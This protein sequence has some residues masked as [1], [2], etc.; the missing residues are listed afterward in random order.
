VRRRQNAGVA[1]IEQLYPGLLAREG[2]APLAK[3]KLVGMALQ[4]PIG[5]ATYAAVSLAVKLGKT[6]GWTRGR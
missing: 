3:G 6:A 2:K 5:F 4:D 1:E